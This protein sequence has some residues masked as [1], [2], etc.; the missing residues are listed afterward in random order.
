[1]YQSVAPT[2][3]AVVAGELTQYLSRRFGTRNVEYSL[4]P[5]AIPDGWETYTYRLQLRG[6]VP[7]AFRRPLALRVYDGVQGAPRLRRE[8][9]VQK[10]LAELGY[11]VARPLL[12]E[13]DL[14]FLGGPFLLMEWVDGETLLNLLR[15]N[16][17]AL[18]TGPLRLG[19]AHAWL[20]R[21]P[22][23]G[24]PCPQG[25]FLDRRLGELESFA[26]DHNLRDLAPGVA[27]LGERRPPE[28]EAPSLL[29][30][31]FHPGNVL[32]QRGRCAAVLDWAEFDV[33]DRHADVADALLMIDCAR[34]DDSP[35]WERLVFP[36]GRGMTRWGYTA[37]YRRLAPL[38]PAR[39]HYYRGWAALRRLHLYGRWLFDGPQ[40]T[41]CKP[42]V[43]RRLRPQLIARLEEYFRKT[44]GVSVRLGQPPAAARV[45]L[46]CA[47]V[48]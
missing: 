24:F 42:G 31:D 15:W 22:L 7:E 3:A 29:H 8:F 14:G 33:G 26:A 38:D 37:A 35:P 4:P 17:L 9:A 43:R 19:E 40:V 6:P 39:L 16:Y 5:T 34:V 11:P 27:W 32:M 13:E 1:M 41:G 36:I 20:H 48:V 23:E 30:L 2:P 21:L 12:L 28:P 25:S 44:T 47:E 18:W 10:R 45:M 46:P